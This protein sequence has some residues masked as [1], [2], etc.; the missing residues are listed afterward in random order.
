MLITKSFYI[1][2]MKIL[3]WLLGSLRVGKNVKQFF[4]SKN[5]GNIFEDKIHKKE[6]E[7]QGAAVIYFQNILLKTKK[8]N[9]WFAFNLYVIANYLSALI[10]KNIAIAT[11]LIKANFAIC[12]PVSITD[13]Q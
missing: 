10:T 4:A 6:D 8:A 12:L 7:V 1:C 11:M 13:G 2:N 9:L 3:Y 5:G